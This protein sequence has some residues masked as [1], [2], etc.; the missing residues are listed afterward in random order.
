MDTNGDVK[1]DE[2]EVIDP[3]LMKLWCAQSV[4]VY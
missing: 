1:L 2:S 4:E 3:S